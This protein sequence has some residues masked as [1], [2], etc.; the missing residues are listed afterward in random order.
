M[1]PVV[2]L[3]RRAQRLRQQRPVVDAERELAAAGRER[4]AVD[5]DQVAEVEAQQPLHRLGAEHVG[6]RLQLD[7]PAAV[8]EVEER[9]LPLPA[10]GRQ[11]AGDAVA[12]LGLLPGL[13]ALVRRAHRGDRLDARV[14]VRE[15][16]DPVRAQALE[17][18]PPDG[19]Q[20]VGHSASP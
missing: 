3:R 15:R 18:L 9:H 1:Q 4:G 10:A 20:L 2:L 14:G 8:D 5:A 13:Q 12:H 11:P 7:A 16:V 17:L 6:A 19:E